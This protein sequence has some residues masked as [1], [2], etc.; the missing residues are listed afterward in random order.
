MVIPRFS[1]QL[2]RYLAMVVVMVLI[3]AEA[4]MVEDRV[5]PN[6]VLYV[7]D[8]ITLW[9]NVISNMDFHLDIKP[10]IAPLLTI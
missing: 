3:L 1:M 10:R 6:N 7:I 4:V 5:L 8:Y 9:M 2:Q